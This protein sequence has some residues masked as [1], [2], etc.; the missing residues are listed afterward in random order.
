MEESENNTIMGDKNKI[1][2]IDN[3][4]FINTDGIIFENT[5]F[6]ILGGASV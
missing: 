3:I 5:S 1:K 6:L 2:P 4:G